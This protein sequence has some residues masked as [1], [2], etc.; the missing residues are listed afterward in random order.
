MLISKNKP[1]GT[2]EQCQ[3]IE[4]T[5]ACSCVMLVVGLGL[6]DFLRTN[7]S[8]WHRLWCWSPW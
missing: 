6:N 5:D 2:A 7:W 1:C 3:S 8:S 4:E